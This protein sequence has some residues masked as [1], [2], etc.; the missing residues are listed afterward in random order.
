MPVGDPRLAM[1]S[2]KASNYHF[3]IQEHE[4]LHHHVLRGPHFVEGWLTG[5]HFAELLQS[6][7]KSNK[8]GLAF[9]LSSLGYPINDV[10]NPTILY[11]DN[12]AC[13]K[14]CHNMTTTGN[15]HIENPKNATREWV[16]NDTIAV[17]YISGKSNIANIFTK[18]SNFWQ[19]CEQQP[20]IGHK[21]KYTYHFGGNPPKSREPLL[22]TDQILTNQQLTAEELKYSCDRAWHH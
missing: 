14:W 12:D 7:N 16:T 15:H 6:R 10:T 22:R 2:V 4:P 18:E 20:Q 21:P 5:A 13:V 3:Y 9:D 8:Y 19:L 11:N 1:Q 17:Q